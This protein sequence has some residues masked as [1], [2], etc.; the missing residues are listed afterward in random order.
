MNVLN[1]ATDLLSLKWSVLSVYPNKL[2]CLAGIN[3]WWYWVKGRSS[4][5]YLAEGSSRFSHRTYWSR[6][7]SLSKSPRF[8]ILWSGLFYCWTKDVQDWFQKKQSIFQHPVFLVESIIFNPNCWVPNHSLSF[9][10]TRIA[11]IFW[12]SKCLSGCPKFL[13]LKIYSPW[14]VPTYKSFPF[15]KKQLI[16][17][18]RT[19]LNLEKFDFPWLEKTPSVKV[20]LYKKPSLSL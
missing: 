20:P 18:G 3:H 10:S 9:V 2:D 12:F 13:F 1:P 6:N 5:I 16:R 4:A 7:K 8:W 15:S 11:V 19:W 14:P 17:L